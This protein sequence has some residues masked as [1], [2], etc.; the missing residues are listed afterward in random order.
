MNEPGKLRIEYPNTPELVISRFP[1]SDLGHGLVTSS[2]RRTDLELWA[3]VV[4]M[5]DWIELGDLVPAHGEVLW[6]ALC[7]AA[8]GAGSSS[9]S[10][11]NRSSSSDRAI[12][13]A[14]APPLSRD[15]NSLKRAYTGK[16]AAGL[17]S[18]SELPTQR[19]RSGYQ[20]SLDR[21][22]RL[23]QHGIHDRRLRS[24]PRQIEGIL[25]LALTDGIL[26]WW[27]F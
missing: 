21:L 8:V 6:D 18:R 13:A 2:V 19:D 20:L 27:S 24:E 9:R 7:A 22:I 14:R 15:E 4:L 16:V 11:N 5:S 23:H 1:L 10:H 3:S 12:T 17:A 26:L 25:S